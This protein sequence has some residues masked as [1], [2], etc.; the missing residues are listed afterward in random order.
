MLLSLTMTR[1]TNILIIMAG[2]AVM[3]IAVPIPSLA[4]DQYV[5]DIAMTRRYQLTDLEPARS[6][7]N[8][9]CQERR[10]GDSSSSR[11]FFL[12][13]P[14]DSLSTWHS[15]DSFQRIMLNDKSNTNTLIHQ[16]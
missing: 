11:E 1:A 5:V 16:Q 2:I 10:V 9:C 13:P 12:E 7:A 14:S 3:T 8:Q 4:A 15:H 6:G